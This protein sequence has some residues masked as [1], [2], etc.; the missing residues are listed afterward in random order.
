METI[1]PS[2]LKAYLDEGKRKFLVIDV[3][4]PWEYKVC[5]IEGSRHIPMAQIAAS[6]DKLQPDVETVV[7]CHHG[8]RSFQVANYLEQSGF[9]RVSNLEG[10]IDAWAREVDPDMPQY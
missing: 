3:R 10:G 2:E 9:S 8:T 5:H 6:K 1:T 7:I 4:E